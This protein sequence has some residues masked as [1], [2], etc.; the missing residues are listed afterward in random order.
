MRE[1]VVDFGRIEV[2]PRIEIHRKR[3]AARRERE[4]ALRHKGFGRFKHCDARIV[5]ALVCYARDEPEIAAIL[6]FAGDVE[7]FRIQVAGVA[8]GVVAS[9][10]AD[11][12]AAFAPNCF[13]NRRVGFAVLLVSG[14][15][16]LQAEEAVGV[17]GSSI[18]LKKG[19]KKSS[20]E[21]MEDRK[22]RRLSSQPLEYPSA[23]SVFRNP[24]G[25]YA[26]RLIESCN[27]KGTNIGD[28]YVS[29]KHANFIINKGHATSQDV[30]DLILLV[31]D[32]VLQK[33]NV[34]MV[35]E[36]EF[37]GWE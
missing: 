2:Q 10:G 14:M 9:P 7:D 16:C 18:Y 19:E 17:E 36:Q 6:S 11:S 23:G 35:I 27:L 25:D 34:D 5:F 29:E 20:L 24:E 3:I 32:T 13:E 12:R 1:V 28:A 22:R 4:H 15:D 33:T 8:L 30:H 37:I 21:I 31:H 26:G